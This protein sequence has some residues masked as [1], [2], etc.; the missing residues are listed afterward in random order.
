MYTGK[1]GGPIKRSEVDRIVKPGDLEEVRLNV[2]WEE[3]GPRLMNQ[4]AFNIACLANVKDTNFEY[5]AQDDFRVEKP[6]IEIEVR[7]LNPV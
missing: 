3:Y 1:V 2:S 6:K 7:H 4:C 5:Y